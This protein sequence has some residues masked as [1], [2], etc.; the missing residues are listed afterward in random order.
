M[1]PYKWFYRENR[2]CCI[3]TFKEEGKSIGVIAG[4]LDVLCVFSTITAA[5]LF[6]YQGYTT[7]EELIK[8]YTGETK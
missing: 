8:Y 6:Y 1:T 2:I 4:N 7:R 5:P 3:D